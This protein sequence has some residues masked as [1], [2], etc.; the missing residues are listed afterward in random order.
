MKLR[1]LIVIFLLL[2][3]G[4]MA[5]G[6]R[7]HVP[8]P[9]D[10][11]GE[12]NGVPYLIRVPANWNGTL[13]VYSYGYAEAFTDPLPLAPPIVDVNT[14]LA[15]GFALA[16]IH[17]AGA[18]KIPGA[19]TDAG[20]NVKERIENTAAVTAAFRGLVGRPRRTIMWGQSMGGLVTLA[21][22][23]KFPGLYDGAVPLCAPGA[24]TPRMMDQRLDFRLAYAVAFGWNDAWGTPDNLR[25][26]L[27]VITEVFPHVVQQLTP[28]KVWRWE[29]LRLVNRI[30]ADPSFYASPV[31][32]LFQSVWLSFAPPLELGQRAGGHVA[33]NIGRVYILRD[34]D[35]LYLQNNF[36]VSKDSLDS[37]LEAMNDQTIYASDR[38][39]R[40]YAEHYYN[41]TG[42]IR[43][44]VLTLH[45]TGDAAVI[46]NNERAYRTAVKQHGNPKLLM[47]EF[48]TGNGVVNTHCTFTPAQILAGIDAMIYWLDTGNRPDPSVFFPP[49]LGFDPSFAPQ[50]WPW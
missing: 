10:L 29:F 16:G 40:R 30:P 24:G 36:G 34:A 25:A 4:A 17:A 45:T 39:A 3:C 48:S 1:M 37:L 15:K 20:W 38:N 13:L 12:L 32:F 35:R 27:N 50:P 19:A 8:L 33:Q 11:Q 18:V 26:D 6:K 14:L 7:V 22:I 23:E 44:P 9:A 21:M 47:Q 28:D 46:P 43:R 2:T 41:P 42:R 5:S 31:P 49:A